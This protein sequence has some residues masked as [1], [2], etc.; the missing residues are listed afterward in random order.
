MTFHQKLGH[1]C[2]KSGG[3]GTVPPLQ[4]VGGTRTP[5]TATLYAYGSTCSISSISLPFKTVLVRSVY[6]LACQ[7]SSANHLSYKPAGVHTRCRL[8]PCPDLRC[9]DRRQV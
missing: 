1:A 8:A 4:K 9:L 2:L 3:G 6:V 7:F 5:R